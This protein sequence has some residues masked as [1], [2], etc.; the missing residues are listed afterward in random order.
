MEAT[1]TLVQNLLIEPNHKCVTCLKHFAEESETIHFE[2]LANS[3]TSFSKV[4]KLLDQKNA[5]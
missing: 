2:S 3:D 1:K 4:I 5:D